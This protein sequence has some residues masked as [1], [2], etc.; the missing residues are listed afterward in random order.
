MKKNK[1]IEILTMNIKDLNPVFFSFACFFS[2][3]IIGLTCFQLNKSYALFH[4]EIIGEKDIKVIVNNNIDDVVVTNLKLISSE[5]GG[6]QIASNYT[7]YETT[8]EVDLPNQNSS[9]IY[10]VTLKSRGQIDFDLIKIIEKE[11][12]N[13]NIKYDIEEITIG[14]EIASQTYKTF[15]IRFYKEETA[16]DS[17]TVLKLQYEYAQHIDEFKNRVNN[18]YELTNTYSYNDNLTFH[19]KNKIKSN[20]DGSV[21]FDRTTQTNNYID[22]KGLTGDYTKGLTMVLDFYSKGATIGETTENYEA[23]ISARTIVK[24]GLTLW[25]YGE[26]DNLIV[27]TGGSGYRIKYPL[28]GA[29][30]YLVIYTYEKDYDGIII[31]NKTKKKIV[32]IETKEKNPTLINDGIKNNNYTISIGG[33]PS[34]VNKGYFYQ[35]SSNLKFYSFYI[36]DSGITDHGLVDLVRQF[37]YDLVNVDLSA[38]KK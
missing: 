32:T 24:E 13:T 2:I 26:T 21:S 16:E 3:F 23:L 34:L 19:N 8:I 17:K 6:S 15:K 9:L 10:E 30:R 29:A 37:G 35:A 38:I 1:L 14:D 11:Y 25:Y 27:D 20:S 18:I 28:Q 4:N 22:I 36:N 5:N 33:E 12:T 7:N 31:I